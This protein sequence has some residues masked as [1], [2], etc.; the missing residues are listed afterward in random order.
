MKDKKRILIFPI[1]IGLLTLILL[2]GIAQNIVML[3]CK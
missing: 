2:I 1:V 3:Q